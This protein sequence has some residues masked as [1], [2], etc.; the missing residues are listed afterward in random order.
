MGA[1]LFE[2]FHFLVETS[3]KDYFIDIFRIYLRVFR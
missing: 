2:N 3:K 1:K